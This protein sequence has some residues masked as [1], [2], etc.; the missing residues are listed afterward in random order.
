MHLIIRTDGGSR[1]N[2]GPAAAGVLISKKGSK[3]IFSGGFYLGETTNNVAE[4]TALVRALE[5]AEQLGGTRLDVFCDSE[6]VV[7]QVN[8]QY[9]VKNANLKSIYNKVIDL[10]SRFE[11]VNVNHVYRNG[12][13][14]ADALVNQ[15]LD[16]KSDVGGIVKEKPENLKALES[17]ASHRQQ[18][19]AQADLHQKINYQDDQP[20]RLV[21]SQYNGQKSEM[22]CLNPGR[23]QILKPRWSQAT[24]TVI[25]GKGTLTVEHDIIPVHTGS[26][27]HLAQ[28]GSVQCSADDNESLALIVTGIV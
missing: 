16:R 17:P 22:I 23:Q 13:T 14:Q 19:I 11:Q 24:I 12:N 28:V 6:L 1:G 3:V 20:Y 25:Q 2:P 9:K 26:W 5:L 27:L 8:G 7:K 18:V 10:I 4:Y 21:L 15:A